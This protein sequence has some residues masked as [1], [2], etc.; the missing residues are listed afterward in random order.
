MFVCRYIKIYKCVSI[1]VNILTVTKQ[2]KLNS[3][4]D[5]NIIRALK[6]RNNFGAQSNS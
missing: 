6:M 1:N 3:R 4:I 5:E 2:L